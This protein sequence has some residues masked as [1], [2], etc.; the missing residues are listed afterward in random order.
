MIAALLA[1]AP[2]KI[3]RPKTPEIAFTLPDVDM[4]A[5]DLTYD[6]PRSRFLVSSVHRGGIDAVDSKGK[7]TRFVAADTWG[8]FA[9]AADEKRNT[10]WAAAAAMPISANFTASDAGQSALLAYDLRTGTSR[11]RYLPPDE[12]AHSFGDLTVSPAGDVYV[13]DGI[14]SG[15]Y[16]LPAGAK[17]L[18]V[19]VPRGVLKSPQTP[20][21]SKDGQTLYVP[22]YDQG[23]AAVDVKTGKLRLLE[24]DAK[25]ILQGIDGMYLF[26]DSL[27]AVQNGVLPN[28]IVRLTL[29]G[30][31][32][33]RL[34]VVV[35]AG[36]ASELTHAAIKGSW[37]YFII[38]SGWDR[39]ED[40][41]SMKPGT[42]APAVARVRL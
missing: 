33:S 10:L 23:I 42:D 29:S 1:A 18:R 3:V 27:I 30:D 25:M 40:K 38:R 8:L 9:I 4:I 22:D 14:G 11:G 37:L 36:I 20:V 17:A 13:A 34:D 7:V 32:V 16:V 41:G 5:E 35:R 28:R 15:V 24:H 26:K 21:L 12:G 39:A 19:L 31:G 6:A 2:A